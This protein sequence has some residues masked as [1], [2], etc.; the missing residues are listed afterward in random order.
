MEDGQIKD[1]QITASSIHDS[2]H[3]EVHAR[4]NRP[5]GSGRGAGAWCV[6]SNNQNEWIQV[7]FGGLQRITGVI[8]QGRQD[9]DQV[10]KICGKANRKILII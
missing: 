8:T 4:L 1:N 7:D 9:Y 10:L 5:G 2:D 6:R 3:A